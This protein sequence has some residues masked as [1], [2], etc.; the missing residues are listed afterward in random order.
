MEKKDKEIYFD[1]DAEFSEFCIASYATIAFDANDQP[2]LRCGYSDMY[3]KY[4]DQGMSFYIRDLDSQVCKRQCVSKRVPIKIEGQPHYNQSTLVSLKVQNLEDYTMSKEYMASLLLDDYIDYW[5]NVIKAWFQ[6]ADA[7]GISDSAIKNLSDPDQKNAIEEQKVIIE[8]INTKRKVRGSSTWLN[9]NHMPEP[10]WGNPKDC[11]IV[12]LDF[13]PGGGS[14]INKWT[15]IECFKNCNCKACKESLT[16]YVYNNSYSDLALS[17][18]LIENAPKDLNDNDISWI[19]NYGGCKW[20]QEKKDWLVE[21]V[22]YQGIKTD[23]KPFAMELCGWHSENW[24]GLKLKNNNKLK[25]IVEDRVVEPLLNAIQMSQVNFAISLGKPF[26]DS[27]FGGYLKNVSDNVYN[28]ISKKIPKQYVRDWNIINALRFTS[29]SN[30]TYR[31]YQVVNTNNYIINTYHTGGHE[32]PGK[33]WKDFNKL[34][35]GALN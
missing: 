14:D 6:S 13:N 21:L 28:S 15:S 27:L 19:R 3:K 12:I 8:S 16:D 29:P 4:V 9:V 23:K 31:I 2:K 30:R 34:I 18:P 11:S 35:V 25:S 20:W 24:G 22:E 33:K 5:D 17:F 10:Y 32:T 1:S 7:N 26:D